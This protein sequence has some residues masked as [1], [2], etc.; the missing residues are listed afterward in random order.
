MRVVAESPLL[1]GNTSEVVRIGATVRRPSG[2]WTPAVHDLLRYLE[3]A[4]FAESPRVLGSDGQGREILSFIE[5]ET[6]MQHPWP[7]WAWAEDTLA[8]AGRLLRRYHDTVATFPGAPRHWLAGPAGVAPGQ[9]VCH[10]DFAPYNVV[11][12]DGRIIGLIDWDWAG[13]AAPEWDL[14]MAA[15]AWVPLLDPP[16]AARLEPRPPADLGG[17]LR[18]LLDSYGLSDREGF[19]ALVADRVQA[20]VDGITALANQGWARYGA[21]VETG[22]V[23]AMAGAVAFLRQSAPALEAAARG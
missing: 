13:P 2:H 19:V 11:Y 8:Q 17:R 10:N 1:G 3:A 12:R 23:S 9:V 7:D 16:V 6:T 18:L 15:Y 20:S 5:G 21:L 14:A 22:H 4:G